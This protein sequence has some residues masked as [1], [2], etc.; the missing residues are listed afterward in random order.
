MQEHERL[1]KTKP[2]AVVNLVTKSQWKSKKAGGQYKP[3][4]H[5]KP[6]NM[7]GK[8]NDKNKNFQCYFCKRPGHL[9][10]DYNVFKNWRAKQGNKLVFL[11]KLI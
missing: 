3:N 2:V 6:E 7:K 4:L 1:K 11:S 9:K 10:M 8:G 5:K